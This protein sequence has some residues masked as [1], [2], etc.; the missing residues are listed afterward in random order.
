MIINLIGATENYK[1]WNSLTTSSIITGN[2]NISARNEINLVDGFNAKVGETHIFTEETFADCPEYIGFRQSRA[3]ITSLENEIINDKEISLTF[4]PEKKN[5]NIQAF[6]NPTCGFFNCKLINLDM[7]YETDIKIKDI[8]GKVILQL[9]SDQNL[10]SFD[11]SLLSPGL[12]FIEAINNKNFVT[13][14]LIVQ[15]TKP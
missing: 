9:I 12:Y 2:C 5:F 10:V 15:S 13:T 3:A 1:G 11:Q 6:P 4:L 8:A 7:E 14:K